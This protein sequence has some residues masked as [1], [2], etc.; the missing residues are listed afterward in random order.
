MSLAHLTYGP[1]STAKPYLGFG[2]I[3]RP[4]LKARYRVVERDAQLYE[5]ESFME[6]AV[7]R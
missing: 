2:N 1:K 4:I 7:R 3:S 6:N 5:L